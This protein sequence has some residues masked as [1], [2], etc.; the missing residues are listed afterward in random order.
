VTTVSIIIWAIPR[1]RLHPTANGLLAFFFGN[2]AFQFFL[3]QFAVSALAMTGH[4]ELI[5]LLIPLMS[6][7]AVGLL[8]LLYC[9]A[10]FVLMTIFILM[11]AQTTN[12]AISLP[13]ALV[14]GAATH[15]ALD[16]TPV[17]S[18]KHQFVVALVASGNIVIGLSAIF[19][20]TST[21]VD[22]LP[23]G[24]QSHF[25]MFLTCDADCGSLE[26]YG[27]PGVRAAVVIIWVFLFIL[28]WVFVVSCTRICL[29]KAEL[30]PSFLCCDCV[31]RNTDSWIRMKDRRKPVVKM[32]RDDD[33]DDDNDI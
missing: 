24:C 30:K 4:S 8:W 6:L 23:F 26:N 29:R 15:F 21:A 13:V 17:Y 31:E 22:S 19:L 7:L 14:F 12:I 3:L 10:E 32:E 27:A 25:N 9:L 1:E 2:F 28:R 33:S 16:Y 20:E 5:T 11:V 18:I